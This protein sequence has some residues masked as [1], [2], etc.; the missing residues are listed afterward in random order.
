MNPHLVKYWQQKFKDKLEKQFH[1]NLMLIN[2]VLLKFVKSFEHTEL[3]ASQFENLIHMVQRLQEPAW[4][5]SF[6]KNGKN[7]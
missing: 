4:N 2:A 5:L 6:G 3:L 1:P 7:N